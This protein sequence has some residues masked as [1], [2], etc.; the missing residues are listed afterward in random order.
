MAVFMSFVWGLWW[1]FYQD[2]KTRP[3]SWGRGEIRVLAEEG[4]FTQG[5]ID[6]FSRAEK[7]ILKVTTKATPQELLREL[8]SHHQDYDLIQFSSFLADSFILENVFDEVHDDDINN[9]SNISVDFKNLG[10]DPEN[11]FVIPL[12]WGVNGYVYNSKEI[13]EPDSIIELMANEKVRPK[14]S[15]LPSPVELYSIATHLKPIVKTWVNTGN[16]DGVN[17]E[18]KTV[19]NA[20]AQFEGAPFES[21]K[22]GKL[23]V[24]QV[25]NGDAA[26]FLSENP[27]FKYFVPEERAN[28]WV[29]VIGISRDSKNKK[30][31][32]DAIGR[33][34]S[35]KWNQY[36]VKTANRATVLS[37]LNS[38]KDILPLQKSQFVREIRLSRFE[39]FYDRET[40]EPVWN[41]A[42]KSVFPDLWKLLKPNTAE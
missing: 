2:V 26:K 7:I 30:L 38:S 42:I 34:L 16:Q 24:S 6:R 21:L 4:H 37:S 17:Q 13:K 18:L 41:A 22:S 10:F 19:K 40:Y 25:A 20:I 12:F 23:V 27:D 5:F 11:R 9:F 32:E 1:G 29:A 3:Y 31:A 39:L 28:L 8:L 14:V 35:N 15:F 33:M 36:L